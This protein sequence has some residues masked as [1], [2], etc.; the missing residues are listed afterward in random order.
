MDFL[1]GH[2][3]EQQQQHRN[4]LPLLNRILISWYKFDEYYKLTDESPAFT[5]AILLHPRLRRSYL[6][7]AWS[8]QQQYISPAI[9]EARNLWRAHYKRTK[10]IEAKE[11]EY[12]DEIDKW[13]HETYHQGHTEDEFE[14]FING[15]SHMVGCSAIEWWASPSQIHLYPCLH[16][17]AFD[18]FSIPPMSAEVE[19]VFSGARRTISW[20]RTKL[21][22]A[23]IEE[24]ECLKHWLRNEVSENTSLSAN[25]V[26]DAAIIAISTAATT[27]SEQPI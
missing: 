5:T 25:Q 21:T 22:A 24:V 7:K 8:H 15:E 9:D 23:T 12:L 20:E 14:R 6:E 13:Q 4:N 19:R 11:E 16:Q 17:M 2:Y 1:V 10:V 3:K 27:R 26:E 18:V